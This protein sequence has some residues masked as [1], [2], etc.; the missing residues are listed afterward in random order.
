MVGLLCGV[1]MVGAPRSKDEDKVRYVLV[2]VNTNRA[3]SYP[4]GAVHARMLR[5]IEALSG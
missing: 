5:D 4:C 1:G 2:V 3:F